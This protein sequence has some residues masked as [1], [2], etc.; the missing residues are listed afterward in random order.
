MTDPTIDDLQPADLTRKIPAWPLVAIAALLVASLGLCATA[1]SLTR[2]LAGLAVGIAAYI[3][4]LAHRK[5]AMEAVDSPDY[6]RVRWMTT[7]M[8]VL[9][10]AAIALI[11][12]NSYP[13]ALEVAER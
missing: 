3:G 8:T 11:A 2:N 12:W 1:L 5:V 7:A 9:L 13:I 6:E 10:V 4:L